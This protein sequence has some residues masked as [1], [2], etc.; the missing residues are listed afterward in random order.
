MAKSK[1]HLKDLTNKHSFFEDVWD[2]ARQI[3]KGRVTSY[4]AIAGYL[5]TKMSA[6]MVGW[7]MSAAG[8]TKP[9]VPAHRVVNSVGLLSGK[10]HFGSHDEMQKRLEKEKIKVEKD[11]VVDFD[12]LFWDPAKELLL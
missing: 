2:V 11:K 8:N 7:A 9:E 5:G 1:H 3:P 4:G 6:R 12:K 10:M